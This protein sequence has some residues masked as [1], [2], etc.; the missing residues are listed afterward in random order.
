MD[1]MDAGIENGIKIVHPADFLSEAKWQQD[2]ACGW[3][4]AAYNLQTF[5]GISIL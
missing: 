2:Q 3:V 5:S 4:A 1:S